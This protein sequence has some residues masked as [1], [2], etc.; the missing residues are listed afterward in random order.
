MGSGLGVT[1]FFCKFFLTYASARGNLS[2]V[3]PLAR[4]TAPLIA[5]M[6]STAFLHEPLTLHQFAGVMV[7]GLGI[8][9]MPGWVL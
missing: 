1:H 8:L 2:R 5:G 6:V 3:Y 4:G 7:L 9:M